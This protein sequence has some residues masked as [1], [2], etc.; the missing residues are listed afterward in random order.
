[1]PRQSGQVISYF[2]P[3]GCLTW[4]VCKGLFI[5]STFPGYSAGVRSWSLMVVAAE[6]DHFTKGRL[7]ASVAGINP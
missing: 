4:G 3:L 2:I 6:T 1:M 7:F 5:C